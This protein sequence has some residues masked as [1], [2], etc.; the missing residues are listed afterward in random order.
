MQI[1]HDLYTT[2][3]FTSGSDKEKEII[4]DKRQEQKKKRSLL[5]F[6]SESDFVDEHIK[7]SVDGTILEVIKAGSD[8]GST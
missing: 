6:E 8:P 3:K 1:H 7:T 4:I 2:V 5:S